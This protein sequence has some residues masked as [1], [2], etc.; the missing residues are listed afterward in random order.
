MGA[1]WKNETLRGDGFT[2]NQYR[3]GDCLKGGIG[4]SANLKGSWHKR[5]GSVFEEGG[6][7]PDAHYAITG[8]LLIFYI[9]LQQHNSLTLTQVILGGKTGFFGQKVIQ[10]N[11]F[12]NILTQLVFLI[13]CMDKTV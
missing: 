2:K 10:N 4:Q 5:W 3:G 6:W 11:N 8:N 9:M 12:Y 7:Y 1:Y 13:F